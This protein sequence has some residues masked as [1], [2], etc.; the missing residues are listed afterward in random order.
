MAYRYL[1]ADD[2]LAL[3]R[4]LG[5]QADVDAERLNAIVARPLLAAHYDNADLVRQAALL[6]AGLACGRPFATLNRQLALIA[7][8][9][10]IVLNG[11][12]LAADPAEFAD[13][14]GRLPPT[15]D[16]ATAA[17]DTWL[18]RHIRFDG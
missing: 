4:W 6:V 3:H 12:L 14:I 11:F 15:V 13:Q 1:S 7:G 2:L 5:G 9:A 17:L 16:D 10:F 18:R 8:D